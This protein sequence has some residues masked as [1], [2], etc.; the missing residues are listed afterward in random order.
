MRAKRLFVLFL[1][2]AFFSPVFKPLAHGMGGEFCEL[3][4]K[5]ECEHGE[6]CHLKEG[7]EGHMAD[8]GRNGQGKRHA[9]DTFLECGTKSKRSG[10]S[11]SPREAPFVAAFL[12]LERVEESTILENTS[13]HIYD[14]PTVPVRERP[15][16]HL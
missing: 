3:S 6:F 10:L 14:E 2:F 12:S 8:D 7:H 11:T 13:S 1:I 15:P 4:K 9:C 16:A 5:R